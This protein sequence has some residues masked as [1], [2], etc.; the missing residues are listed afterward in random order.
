MQ[1]KIRL[2]KVKQAALTCSQMKIENLLSRTDKKIFGT[3]KTSIIL[4][5]DIS[6][7]GDLGKKV[8]QWPAEK[9]AQFGDVN[10]LSFYI[11]E[12]KNIL[13]PYSKNE[14]NYRLAK[15]SLDNCNF[16]DEKTLS[17]LSFP[18]CDKPLKKSKKRKSRK[19]TA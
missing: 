14:N 8:C 12:Y 5:D 13:V 16:D 17:E 11:D 1:A 7:V 9:F 19:K 2:H 4:K 15:I 6:V 18:K 10:K 3:E